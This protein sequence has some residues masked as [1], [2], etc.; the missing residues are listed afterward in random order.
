MIQSPA[1]VY[2]TPA[3][4]MRVGKNPECDKAV[5]LD[6]KDLVTHKQRL[7]VETIGK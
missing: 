4:N 2:R 1:M 7:T 3:N 5:S 6:W